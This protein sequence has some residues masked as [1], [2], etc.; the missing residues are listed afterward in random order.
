MSCLENLVERIA[1][2]SKNGGVV[3]VESRVRTYDTEPNPSGA[4]V[5]ILEAVV[6][7]TE[8]EVA[9]LTC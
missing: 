9:I 6:P 7:P 4:L 8:V 3:P 5:S 1:L 2:R